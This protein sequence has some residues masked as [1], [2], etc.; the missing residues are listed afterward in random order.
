M[1]GRSRLGRLR[2]SRGG[3]EKKEAKGKKYDEAQKSRPCD[4]KEVRRRKRGRKFQG[5]NGRNGRNR[6]NGRN[7]RNGRR[8]KE[9]DRGSRFGFGGAAFEGGERRRGF[10]DVTSE[11]GETRGCGRRKR[12]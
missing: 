12:V 11:G 8:S 6:R 4:R 10:G 2:G 9:G 7:G 1:E 5:R 3:L